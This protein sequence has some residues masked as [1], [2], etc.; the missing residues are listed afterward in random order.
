MAN[1]NVGLVGESFVCQSSWERLKTNP[2][3]IID[4][5]CP[6]SATTFVKLYDE[7]QKHGVAPGDDGGHLQSL[8][9]AARRD[10][11][12]RIEGFPQGGNW[13]ECVAAE[14]AISKKVI[15]AGLEV[16]QINDRRRFKYVA[17]PQWEATPWMHTMKNKIARVPVRSRRIAD[18]VRRSVQ[19]AAG[20]FATAR[21][22]FG[23]RA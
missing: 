20:R 16:K 18:S 21:L 4:G 8:I 3:P 17:H 11:L 10:V 13:L 9:L 2:P 12:E 7:I 5:V 6:S 14:I 23:Q 1:P 22:A 15:A 19:S